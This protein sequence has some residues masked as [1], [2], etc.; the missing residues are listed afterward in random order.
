MIFDAM[1]IIS[2]TGSMISDSA[3][4]ISYTGLT[5]PD[6]ESMISDAAAPKNTLCYLSFC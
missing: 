6:A 1:V 3:T 2:N 5:I 4:M